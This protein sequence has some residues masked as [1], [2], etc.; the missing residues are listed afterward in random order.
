[1][2]DPILCERAARSLPALERLRCHA[3]DVAVAA[4]HAVRLLAVVLDVLVIAAAA[5]VLRLSVCKT[6]G[7]IYAD[8]A[9]GEVR[10]EAE[11]VLGSRFVVAWCT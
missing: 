6:V 3:E 4:R 7:V 5:A 10:R 11:E 9:D 1:M 2:H 8:Q